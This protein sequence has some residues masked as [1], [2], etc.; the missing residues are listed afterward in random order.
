M[1]RILFSDISWRNPWALPEVPEERQLTD[2]CIV[3]M[4][5]T[6]ICLGN[7]C[8]FDDIDD[9]EAIL[10]AGG[11]AEKGMDVRAITKSGFMGEAELGKFAFTLGFPQDE[12]NDD[13]YV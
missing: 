9:R 2:D 11:R 6:A 13:D 5:S 12:D 7:L 3:E 10:G 4:P 8:N 1:E